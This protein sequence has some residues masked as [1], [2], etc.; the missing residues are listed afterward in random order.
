MAENK[1]VL[2]EWKQASP[3]WFY[4]QHGKL[5]FIT[6]SV[7]VIEKRTVSINGVT[8]TEYRTREYTEEERD[9]R[10]TW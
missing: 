2:S 9:D 4:D 3:L 1:V 10:V 7:D 8:K 5:R 6:S